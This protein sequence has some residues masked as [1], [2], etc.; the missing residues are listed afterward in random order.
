MLLCLTTTYLEGWGF[1]SLFCF[2]VFFAILEGWEA[3]SFD[4]RGVECKGLWE[5]GKRSLA[6][7]SLLLRFP[8]LMG[9]RKKKKTVKCS[10]LQFATIYALPTAGGLP[11]R[12]DWTKN[13]SLEKKE[14]IFVFEK[15]V[16]IGFICCQLRVSYMYSDVEEPGSK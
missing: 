1:E 9:G 8:T 3:I 11:R 13:G 5:W 15:L 4:L 6:K 16:C 7:L 10:R 12:G 2:F 14:S